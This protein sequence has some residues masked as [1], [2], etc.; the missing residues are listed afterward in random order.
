MHQS[1]NSLS[2]KEAERSANQRAAFAKFCFHKSFLKYNLSKS[3]FVRFSGDWLH[4]SS[5][6]SQDLCLFYSLSDLES[7]D[8]VS[9]AQAE[10]FWINWIFRTFN[11]EKVSYFPLNPAQSPSSDIFQLSPAIF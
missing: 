3:R 4:G 6:K 2:H 11:T 1:L 7:L 5:P 8:S 9:I 10:I